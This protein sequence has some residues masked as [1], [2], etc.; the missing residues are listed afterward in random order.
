MYL[1]RRFDE[2]R[3]ILKIV[4]KKNGANIS[5]EE[6]DNFIFEFENCENENT[7]DTDMEKEKY[8]PVI[9]DEQTVKLKGNIIDI[10]T[11]WQIRTNFICLNIIFCSCLFCFYLVN[12]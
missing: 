10:F 6:I 2:T 12:F 4:A 1:N 11:I 7:S 5:N 9:M 3:Q 8:I